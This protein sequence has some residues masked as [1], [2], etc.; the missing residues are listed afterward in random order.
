MFNGAG[1]EVGMGGSVGQE[2]GQGVGSCG[3][4]WGYIKGLWG[5]IC[6]GLWVG[7]W[8]TWG[9]SMGQ[10]GGYGADYVVVMGVL[11]RWLRGGMWVMWA[12]GVGI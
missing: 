2:M 4:L 9:G 1:Y 6:S 5:R 8:E 11:W 3:E 10:G 7:L 12:Y